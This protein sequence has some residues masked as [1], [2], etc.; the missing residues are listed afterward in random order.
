MCA[1]LVIGTFLALAT[2]DIA[3]NA[4]FA[5]PAG[6]LEV[7]SLD[8][9][10][11]VVPWLLALPFLGSTIANLGAPLLVACALVVV[12][13]LACYA[14]FFARFGVVRPDET[15]RTEW[16]GA[17][18]EEEPAEEEPAKEEAA[19]GNREYFRNLIEETN[20]RSDGE[21]GTTERSE[22]ER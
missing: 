4:N 22:A 11:H 19:K 10:G 8:G 20:R 18:T 15:V 5:I 2:T 13:V 7:S 21:A 12:G 9:G 6:T 14:A 1:F 17:E 16:E 3:G